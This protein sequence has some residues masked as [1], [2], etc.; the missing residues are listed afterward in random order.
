[1][2]CPARVNWIAYKKEK[3]ALFLF[4]FFLFVRCL[5]CLFASFVWVRVGVGVGVCGCVCVDG[6]GVCLCHFPLINTIIMMRIISPLLAYYMS[7]LF[8]LVHAVI[9]QKNSTT[10]YVNPL[11]ASK[12]YHKLDR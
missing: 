6:V 3:T 11:F 2:R 4:S 7:E 5:V 8:L 12:P 1:M 10:W 9:L